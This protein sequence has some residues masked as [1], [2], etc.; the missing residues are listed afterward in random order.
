VQVNA[1][2]AA[3]AR[4][5]RRVGGR[6]GDSK[7]SSRRERSADRVRGGRAAGGNRSRLYRRKRPCR[8]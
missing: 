5:R 3:S 7:L 4:S 6:A 2:A 8:L 1:S